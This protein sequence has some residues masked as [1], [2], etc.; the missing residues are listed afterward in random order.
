M[1]V[2]WILSSVFGA[3]LGLAA[4]AGAN[5]ANYEEAKALAAKENKPV[6]VDFYAT[7]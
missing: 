4:V 1:Q 7:W 2:R 3:A 5:P 6:L